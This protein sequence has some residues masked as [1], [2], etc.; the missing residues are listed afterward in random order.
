MTLAKRKAASSPQMTRS[1]M[2][3]FLLL[4]LASFTSATKYL[5]GASQTSRKSPTGLNLRPM[6]SS[7]PLG[8]TGRLPKIDL[9]FPP[10]APDWIQIGSRDG[11]QHALLSYCL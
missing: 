6:A 8:K 11:N 2:S 1:N 10:V 4:K 5:D 3:E 9:V 7:R